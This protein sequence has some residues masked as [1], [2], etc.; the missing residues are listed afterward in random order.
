M[1]NEKNMCILYVVCV[2]PIYKNVHKHAFKRM[3]RQKKK[4]KNN[5]K[6]IKQMIFIF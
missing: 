5:M 2:E 3:K 4:K 6:N 1:K